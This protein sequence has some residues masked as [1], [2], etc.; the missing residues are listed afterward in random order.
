M[1]PAQHL[2]A[3]TDGA[4]SEGQ[5]TFRTEAE[6]KKFLQGRRNG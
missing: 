4:A 1:T 6:Y 5:Q 2:E 3:L